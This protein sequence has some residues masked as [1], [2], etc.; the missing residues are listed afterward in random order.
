MFKF[1]PGSS[2]WVF[3]AL[4]SGTFSAALCVL[5]GAPHLIANLVPLGVSAGVMYGTRDKWQA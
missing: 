2:K 3:I 5:A 1:K 4:I